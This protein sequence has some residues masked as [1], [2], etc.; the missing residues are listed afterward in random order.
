MLLGEVLNISESLTIE[1]K[2]FCLKKCIYDY[3]TREE[4]EEIIDTG[5]LTPDFNKVIYDTLHRYFL[6]YLPKYASGFSNCTHDGTLYIG[7]NDF[8]EVTGIPFIGN[9][10][11]TLINTYVHD[12][13]TNYL[14][15]VGIA[16]SKYIDKINISI[17]ELS[18]DMMLLCDNTPQIMTQMKQDYERYKNEYMQYLCDRHIWLEKLQSYTCKLTII[19]KNKNADICKY[20]E[21]NCDN[22]HI[23][24]AAIINTKESINTPINFEIIL[25]HKD[26]PLHFVYWLLLFK[27]NTIRSHLLKRPKPPL[28][29][30]NQNSAFT[31]LTH[32]SDLRHIF[33]SKNKSIK[34]YLIKIKLPKNI[35]ND[36][37]LEY[38]HPYKDIWNVKKRVVHWSLGPCLLSNT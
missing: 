16:K 26:N 36:C 2:E 38:K 9:I 30:K 13:T 22:S 1:F 19:F 21:T 20:I 37:Y 4:I 24:N 15:S 11:K 10:D 14:R 31:L 32:I 29:P 12:I 33:V 34:Y 5:I 6:F 17:E 27:D 23:R 3:Y 28:F 7:V 25:E 35:N 8:G 18:I